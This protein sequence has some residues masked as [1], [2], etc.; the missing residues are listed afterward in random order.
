MT[1]IE[2]KTTDFFTIKNRCTDKIGLVN[3]KQFKIKN[4][5]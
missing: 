4:E 1:G 3:E 5:G 2:R